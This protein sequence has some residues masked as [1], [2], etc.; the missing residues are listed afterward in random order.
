MN[1]CVETSSISYALHRG[2]GNYSTNLL[3]KMLD[4]DHTN[5][6]FI[7]HCYDVERDF[8]FLEQYENVTLIK[9]SVGKPTLDKENVHHIDILKYYKDI[10]KDLFNKII[11]QY[12]IDV[13]YITA[14]DSFS[15][16]EKSYK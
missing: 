12:K 1:I 15:I 3:K 6:Y 2:I 7:L 14:P 13:F 9:C 8:S 10:Y 5:Q 16:F 11:A 4:I